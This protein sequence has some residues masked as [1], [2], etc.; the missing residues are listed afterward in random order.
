MRQIL[1]VS[2]GTVSILYYI[3]YQKYAQGRRKEFSLLFSFQISQLQ[4]VLGTF[5]S[6]HGMFAELKGR[7][8]VVGLI[9]SDS[10]HCSEAEHIIGCRRPK[11]STAAAGVGIC[12]FLEKDI[13]RRVL[14]RHGCRSRHLS[15]SARNFSSGDEILSIVPRKGKRS[16]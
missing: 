4:C 1:I 2:L 7:T 3:I 16:A 14:F 6:K 11:C 13:T 9:S 12:G 8:V 10:F 15:A 5:P